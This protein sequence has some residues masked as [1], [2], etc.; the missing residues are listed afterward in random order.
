MRKP[1]VVLRPGRSR[2]A[3]SAFQIT[4]YSAGFL[5][6]GQ[7]FLE[8][9]RDEHRRALG[10]PRALEMRHSRVG[11]LLASPALAQSIEQPVEGELNGA[12]G[13]LHAPVLALVQKDINNHLEFLRTHAQAIRITGR[14]Q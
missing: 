1:P 4:S 12:G 8:L 7:P 10:D 14:Q 9:D 13:L 5:R 6:S 3:M 11:T 2:A